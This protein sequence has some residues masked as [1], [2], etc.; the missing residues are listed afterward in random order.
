MQLARNSGFR[1]ANSPPVVWDWM[2]D[3]PYVSQCDTGECAG[4]AWGWLRM[5]S[6]PAVAITSGTISAL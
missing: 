5:I 4:T 2:F 1:H 3:T 6:N